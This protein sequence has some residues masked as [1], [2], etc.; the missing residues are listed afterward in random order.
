MKSTR[1]FATL[2]GLQIMILLAIFGQ[3]RAVEPVASAQ[4]PNNAEL[5]VRQLRELEQINA[6]L[7]KLSTLLASGEVQ[8]RVNLP[9][10]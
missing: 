7:D 4:I 6:K 10:D 9:E 1:I 2:I 3:N 5:Q 8:V